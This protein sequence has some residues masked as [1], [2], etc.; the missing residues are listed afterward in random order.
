MSFIDWFSIVSL[1]LNVVLLMVSVGLAVNS[2]RVDKRSKSQVKIWMEQANGLNQAL[3]RIIQNKWADL[4]S[5]VTDVTN[6]V[7]I[8]QAA[9]FSLYQSLYDERVVSEED[10]KTR[11]KKMWEKLEKELLGQENELASDPLRSSRPNKKAKAAS[12]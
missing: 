10:Y 9:S 2:W 12:K 4:Y 7:H 11:Q 8:A 3:V 5:S 1:V 6:S